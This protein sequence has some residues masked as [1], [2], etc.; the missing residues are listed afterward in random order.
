K[1]LTLNATEAG[2]DFFKEALESIDNCVYPED[3]EYA[4]SFYIKEEMLKRLEGRHSFSFK[5]RV[6]FDG[7]PRFFLFTVSRD[8][9]ER[10]LI[11]Y[12]KDIDDEL[13][14]EKIQKENQKKT[15][16]FSQIAESLAS[17][18][19]EIY[20]VNVEDSVYVG[21]A[22]NNLYGQLEIS[23]SGKDFFKESLDNIP[24]VVHRQDQDQVS[25]FITKDNLLSMLEE[26]KDGSIDY[27]IM[28]NGKSRYTRMIARKTSDGTH[29]IIG[30]EDVDE[31]IK[32][33]KRHMKALKT[34]K[35]LARRDEL[36]GVRNKTAYKE[37]EKSV[38]S[39]IDNGMDYLNFALVVCDSNNLK[40]IND[41]LGHAA[42]DEYIKASVQ[43]LCDIFV[44][45]PVFRVGGDEFVVFLRGSDYSSRKELMEKLRSK[46]LENKKNGD[47]AVLASGMAEY[48]PE[49]DSFVSDIFD[50]ADKEMYADK[51]SLKA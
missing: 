23:K 17:N 35:E 30:V 28:V 37:L 42:G 36:T 29:L 13:N 16:T 31:V 32:R 48:Q 14:A 8:I 12:E 45:S 46:V 27:R 49:T 4:K 39:N 22:V 21:Y 3:Q 50:R 41:T 25:E 34:E 7:K 40:M 15:V 9:N 6:M 24:Q 44:H 43:I 18:Y 10:Y 26:R 19:D 1:Y 20:Y 33:E 47:G 2:K 38:Q 11:F 5:Y 51:Q